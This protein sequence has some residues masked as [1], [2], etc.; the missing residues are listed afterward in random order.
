MIGNLWQIPIS[1]NIS[2]NNNKFGHRFI[3]GMIPGDFPMPVEKNHLNLN[4]IPK[5]HL[6][7]NGIKVYVVPFKTLQDLLDQFKRILI[8][9]NHLKSFLLTFL[10]K[11]KNQKT[12]TKN[13][14]LTLHNLQMPLK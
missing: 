7:K 4:K 3:L 6:F 14:R 1:I 11:I 5:E 10:T 13:Q 8:L 2:H 9:Q 12:T